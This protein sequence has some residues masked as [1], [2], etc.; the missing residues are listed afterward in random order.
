M[1][2]FFELTASGQV[3]FRA[4]SSDGLVEL[5][6]AARHAGAQGARGARVL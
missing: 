6:S 1:F 2:E 5:G 4:A 3:F